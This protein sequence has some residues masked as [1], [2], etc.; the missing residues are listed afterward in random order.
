MSEI[1]PPD[2]NVEA[3]FAQVLAAEASARSGVEAARQQAAQIEEDER[4]R[5]R[6]RAERTRRRIA[7]IR[8]VFE[9]RLQAELAVLAEQG[10]ALAANP[11]PVAAD[12]ER[13]DLA[14]QQVTADLTGG[15]R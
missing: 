13:L 11:A 2:S 15:A 9:R 6:A 7:V 8:A 5:A 14:L 1:R 10:A 12:L 4:M 3:A